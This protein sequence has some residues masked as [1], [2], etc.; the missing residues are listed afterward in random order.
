MLGLDSFTK[1]IYLCVLFEM[2]CFA[3]QPHKYRLTSESDARSRAGYVHLV[4]AA[5]LLDK[6]VYRADC[7][8]PRQPPLCTDDQPIGLVQSNVEPI[9]GVLRS[10]NRLMVVR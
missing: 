3:Y 5:V 10:Y 4:V 8:L 6:A 1:L 9:H 2:S 7:S